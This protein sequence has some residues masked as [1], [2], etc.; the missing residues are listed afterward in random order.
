MEIATEE[1]NKMKQ[2]NKQP[3]SKFISGFEK[4]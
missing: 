2:K 4:K 3:F 1:L